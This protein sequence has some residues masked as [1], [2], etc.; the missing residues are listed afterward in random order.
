MQIGKAHLMQTGLAEA[1]RKVGQGQNINTHHIC[2][3]WTKQRTVPP[4]D[5]ILSYSPRI[6]I[7]CEGLTSSQ[8]TH[9]PLS[10]I[11]DSG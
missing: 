8:P 11:N 10:K 6:L 3:S 7:S 9:S 1:N 4:S 2:N 5:N